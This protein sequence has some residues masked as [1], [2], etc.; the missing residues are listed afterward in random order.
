MRFKIILLAVFGSLYFYLGYQLIA[1]PAF[2]AEGQATGWFL[3]GLL[4][5][6]VAWLPLVHW[7]RDEA[8]PSAWTEMLEWCAHLSIGFLSFLLFYCL[9]RDLVLL[10]LQLFLPLELPLYGLPA[11]GVILSLT[12]VSLILGMALALGPP[13]VI[14]VEIPI[15]HLHPGLSELKIVQIS[16]LHIG[17]TI[18][19]K[20]VDRVVEIANAQNAD[21]IALTGDIVDGNVNAI[22]EDIAALAKLQSVHGS[23]YVTGNHEYY[24]GVNPI[25]HELRQNRISPLLNEH[26][27]LEIAGATLVLAGVTDPSAAHYDPTRASSPA[28][29]LEGS[30]PDADLRIL[31]A[32]QPKTSVAAEK[33]GF[34]LQLSGHT[35][36]G[37]FVPWTWVVKFVH[38]FSGGL[39]RLQ[40]LWVYVNLGTGY[41]GPPIRLGA[42]S[43]ITV[44][45]L[46]LSTTTAQ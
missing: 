13:Q 14:K 42:P 46:K 2:S 44:L 10:P 23:F 12:F 20:F 18:R 31:L 21:L 16:D 35:H 8:A 11:T 34:D 38:R 36:G 17:P 1:R 45:Q 4:F 3:L 6:N 29:A 7:E 28:K 39:G 37:Q 27:T 15:A 26:R 33:A 9:I 43:E 22:R 41:W 30:P 40:H 19:K 32:H 5:A 25:L 24:W